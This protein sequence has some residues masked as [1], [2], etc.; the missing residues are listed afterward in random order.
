MTEKK[1]KAIEHEIA[2]FERWLTFDFP[3]KTKE[4]FKKKIESLKKKLDNNS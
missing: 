1:R 4:N 2:C 3:E